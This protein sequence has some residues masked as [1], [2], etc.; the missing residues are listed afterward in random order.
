MKDDQMKVTP[1]CALSVLMFTENKYIH[2]EYNV[3]H[4]VDTTCKYRVFK[5]PH[6]EFAVSDDANFRKIISDDKY[7]IQYNFCDIPM[8]QIKSEWMI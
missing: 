7:G 2:I 6:S 4:N 1:V 5:N 3:M 8:S